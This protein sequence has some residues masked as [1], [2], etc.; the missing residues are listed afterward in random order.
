MQTLKKSHILAIL[1]ALV[2]AAIS[3]A[4]QPGAAPAPKAPATAATAAEFLRTVDEVLADMSNLL[5]LPQT[6][7]LKRTLR[8]R[9]EIRAYILREMDEDKDAAKRATDEKILKRLGLIPRNFPL[10]GYMVDLLSEQI[11]GLYD[12][13]GKEFYIAD[14]IPAADQREVMAHELTHALQ[15]QHFHIDP[16][17]DAAKPNDDAETA[18][19]AVLEGA[20]FVAMMDYCLKKQVCGGK[21]SQPSESYPVL[22]KAP[23]FLKDDLLFPYIDGGNF[24]QRILLSRGGWGGFHTVFENPPVS[25]QQILHPDLY[26]R[27][28]VPQEVKLPDLSHDLPKEWK[29]LDSNLLGEF[30]LQEVLKQF[31]GE[32]RANDLSS[33]WAGD[34]YAFYEQ[35]ETK[36][37]ILFLR[38]HTTSDVNASRLFG[39]LSE[40]WQK[41][42]TMHENLVRRPNYLSF[43]SELGGVFLRCSGSDCVSLEGGDQKLFDAI[44]R[45]LGLTASPSSPTYNNRVGESTRAVQTQSVPPAGRIPNLHR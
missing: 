22:E 5:G 40:A 39:G 29:Q 12:P 24:A 3:H 2:A 25:T 9:E 30:G 44:T 23:P 32:E 16:W 11:A 45:D 41:K 43:D 8:S 17:R 7:P 33:L 21:D 10:D 20:A 28:V 31:L 36:E 13:K 14:W 4:Q 27:G 18:R 42:Y 19:D 35:Q 15:D 26:L 6:E 38:I 37:S 34:R 1:I